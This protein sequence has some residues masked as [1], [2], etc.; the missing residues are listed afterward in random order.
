MR[1]IAFF[2]IPNT[3]Y[4]PCFSDRPFPHLYPSI[5]TNEKAPKCKAI[6]LSY[7]S[8]F[9]L[10][11]SIYSLLKYWQ[12]GTKAVCLGI[13]DV[14]RDASAQLAQTQVFRQ[15]AGTAVRTVISADIYI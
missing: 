13:T 2:F 15:K 7:P 9:P 3:V 12:N 4:I 8:H 6:H 11:C 10:V 1:D 5:Y 14:S